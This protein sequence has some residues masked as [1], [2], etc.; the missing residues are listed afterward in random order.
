[1]LYSVCE[2]VN[3][4][5][6][7]I[8]SCTEK[9]VFFVFAFCAECW[10]FLDWVFCFGKSAQPWHMRISRQR[11]IHTCMP[12]W[13]LHSHPYDIFEL[14]IYLHPRVRTCNIRTEACTHKTYI[15]MLEIDTYHLKLF[16]KYAV[17]I[18]WQLTIFYYLHLLVFIIHMH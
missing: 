11:K 9:A 17:I 13:H 10:L 15:I 12:E 8:E 5:M 1:M 6:C 18:D 16:E 14:Y 4:R 7:S 3:R 2:L